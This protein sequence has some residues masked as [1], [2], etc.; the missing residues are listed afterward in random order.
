MHRSGW[1][2]I[3][4]TSLAAGI[5]IPG[6]GGGG[7]ERVTAAELV[8][9][10]DEICGRERSSFAR[11]QAHPPPNASVAADQT[12]ELIKVTQ[13]ANS[14]LRDL[15]PP[16]GLQSAYDR[17][18]GAR[19]RVIEQM[20][21]GKDAAQD[22]NSDAYGAAQAAVARDAPQRRKLAQALGLTVC[23]AGRATA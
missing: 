23:S 12:D 7:S 2:A 11:I 18:L 3:A 21:R 15:R 19:D 10:A 9:K 13:G 6:C 16:E 4:L 8:R 20:N 17:Y 14:Q 22:Q 5:T 1:I